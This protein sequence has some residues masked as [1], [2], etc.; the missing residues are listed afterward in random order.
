MSHDKAATNETRRFG[1][2]IPQ[3]NGTVDISVG[4]N[5]AG[6]DVLAELHKTVGVIFK[7]QPIIFALDMVERNYQ[8]FLDSIENYRSR[9]ED[10]KPGLPVGI[11][12]AMDGFLSASQKVTN[13]LSSTSAFLAQTE[14]QL[15]RIHGKDSP[16]FNSWD[17]KRK[18]LHAQSFSYRF[19]YELRNFAQHRNIPFS[20][21]NIAGKRPSEELPM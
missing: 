7:L 17:E 20:N 8:E 10:V 12:T 11:S 5:V 13:F 1:Y 21:L 14:M 3:Q 6:A 18:N 15:R 2:Y 16:E 9:L 4:V 19:L